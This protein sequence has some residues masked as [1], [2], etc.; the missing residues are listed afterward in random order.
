MSYLNAP[1]L[2]IGH[3][4]KKCSINV[5]FYKKNYQKNIGHLL[6]CHKY[7]VLYWATLYLDLNERT[8]QKTILS[9][10]TQ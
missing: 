5:I 6:K 9:K 3:K 8:L 4:L 1:N 7:T 2:V 10:Q